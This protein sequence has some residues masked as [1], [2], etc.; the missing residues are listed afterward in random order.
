MLL[1]SFILLAG[2]GMVSAI[3]LSVASKF[4]FVK[5]DPKI[6]A[7]SEALPGANCGGCGFAGCEGYAAAVVTDPTVAANL[8]CVGGPDLVPIIGRLTGKDAGSSEPMRAFRRCQR[9]EGKVK[10][11]F[12]YEGMDNC[13][14]AARLAH[15]TAACEYACLGFGDCVEACPFHALVM[16]NGMPV[17]LTVNC[18]SCGK[19]VKV[20]PRHI[21]TIIPRAARVMVHCSTQDKLKGVSD[22]CEVG[23]I[24]CMKC[25]KSCPAQAVSLDDN[26]IVIDHIKC[27]EYGFSCNEVCVTGCPRKILRYMC[28][29]EHIAENMAAEELAPPPP[30]GPEAGTCTDVPGV[31]RG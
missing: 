29:P 10:K 27:R 20:C 6:A 22:V 9:N 26:R 7:V 24:K 12:I 21:M 14:A 23:C 11:R 18:T 16:R 2:L 17:V 19:C 25:V 28:V 1:N 5:E 31:P 8:C 4:F 13:T 30:P 15:G 3:M